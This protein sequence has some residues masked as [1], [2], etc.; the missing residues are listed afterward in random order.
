MILINLLLLL[1]LATSLS[2]CK[3]EKGLQAADLPGEQSFNAQ[4]Q[5]NEPP[6]CLCCVI[7]EAPLDLTSKLKIV[8]DKAPGERLVIRG[9]VYQSNGKTPAAN[10]LMYFY[11]TD[12]KGIYA[13]RGT[14]DRSSFAWW[15][16][17]H[18]GWLKTDE[19]GR[20]EIETIRPAPYPDG[21]EPAHIHAVIKA[22]SQKNC[23]YLADYVFTDDP[24]LKPAF[25]QNTERWWRS[26]GIS[27]S[28]HYGGVKLTKNENGT[29]EGTRNVILLKE[30]DQ[31]QNLS[32]RNIGD[33]SP[34]FEPQHV[35]GPDKGTRACPMCTYGSL[36]GVLFW[37]NTEGDW[38]NAGKF[39]QW[40]DEE[41]E[42]RGRW[43]FKAYLIYMN[44]QREPLDKVENK[45][46]N[47][48]QNLNLKHIAVTYIPAPDDETTAKLN[49]INPSLKNTVIVF[50]KRRVFD[51]FEN[52]EANEQNLNLLKA[53]VDRAENNMPPKI[54]RPVI[55]A[56]FEL[57]PSGY[58]LAKININGKDALAFIDTGSP[59][60]IELS[61]SFAKN[62][63]PGIRKSEAT[64]NRQAK[65]RIKT[66]FINGYER[67]NLPFEIIPDK[68]IAAIRA[69]SGA[70]V[71]VILG[72]G[73]LSQQYF[74]I[75]FKNQKFL[76]SQGPIELGD[77]KMSFNYRV[78]QGRPVVEASFGQTK[79]NVPINTGSA[80]SEI[81]SALASLSPGKTGSKEINIEGY[82]IT[83]QW[84]IANI[85][86]ANVNSNYPA[87][88][89][90]N[91]LNNYAVY[92]DKTNKMVIFY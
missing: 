81:S 61:S 28:P 32:G 89:G 10:T 62:I 38:E 20:Y 49:E 69:L 24:L 87:T 22:P 78:N 90:N 88:L 18:R 65:A 13:K 48:A 63:F 21:S 53:S 43:K 12:S 34:A 26:I 40:L 30:F 64:D 71:D 2:S 66:L 76:I 74:A 4:P 45:L 5:T 72:W 83:S 92:F 39:A 36:P 17:Y 14:E 58:I 1:A 86:S 19:L 80:I 9:T 42:R 73:F 31:P 85:H 57:P 67:R 82:R 7:D 91:F 56:P 60:F 55:E 75:D 29:W 27:T 37:L 23:Y 79:L 16:G 3:M 54:T 33:Q 41:S 52:F 59:K 68:R 46:T 35:W 47:F 11:H 15:H 51:K 84:K 50:K 77:S 8:D 70:Q 44:P 25:W 6:A